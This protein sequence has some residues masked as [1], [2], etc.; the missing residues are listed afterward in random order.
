MNLT[1]TQFKVLEFMAAGGEIAIL[2]YGAPVAMKRKGLIK[3][4]NEETSESIH[5]HGRTFENLKKNGFITYYYKQGYYHFYVETDIGR[6]VLQK[7]CECGKTFPK[8]GKI[9]LFKTYGKI[10]R[11]CGKCA[12]MLRDKK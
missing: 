10:V 3:T 6:A 9:L 7:T 4:L 8:S 12:K 5:V 1:T 2:D 11:V